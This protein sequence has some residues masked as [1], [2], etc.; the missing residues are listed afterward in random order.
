MCNILL[1]TYSTNIKNYHFFFFITPPLLINVI[2]D[3][4]N[5][6]HVALQSTAYIISENINRCH[7]YYKYINTW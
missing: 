6:L 3:N 1:S 7:M 4:T 2:V 5:I